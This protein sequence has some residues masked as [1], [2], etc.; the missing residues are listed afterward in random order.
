[1]KD[2]ALYRETTTAMTNLRDIMQKIN[3]GQGSVGKLV[4]DTIGLGEFEFDPTKPGFGKITIPTPG[5]G[6]RG[7]SER[8]VACGAARAR[9]ERPDGVASRDRRRHAAA[10][11]GDQAGAARRD[12]ISSSA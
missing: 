8:T 4:N 10:P 5:G 1:M 3:S 12:A 2:E 9:R 6:T 7:A 11:D